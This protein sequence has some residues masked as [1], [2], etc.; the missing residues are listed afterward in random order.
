MREVIWITFP[1]TVILL[2]VIRARSPVIPKRMRMDE[3]V[4]G[5]DVLRA[6]T[7]ARKAASKVSAE[8]NMRSH[9]PVLMDTEIFM[10]WP[11]LVA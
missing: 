4:P 11:V 10:S 9:T 7:A 8:V 3:E 2:Q 5:N 6:A 1:S